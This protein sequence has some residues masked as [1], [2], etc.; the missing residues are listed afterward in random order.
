MVVKKT[1]INLQR[2]TADFSTTDFTSTTDGERKATPV[3]IF[4]MPNRLKNNGRARLLPSCVAMMRQEPHRL[5]RP[6]NVDRQV[7]RP[8]VDS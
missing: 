1:E 5:T 6:S 7:S 8:W 4:A 2:P 3:N